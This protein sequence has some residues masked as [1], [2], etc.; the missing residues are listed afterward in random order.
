MIN[1]K[2]LKF[3]IA[4][5]T[6]MIQIGILDLKKYTNKKQMRKLIG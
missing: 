3:G 5:E 6:I 4:L 1:D 2:I